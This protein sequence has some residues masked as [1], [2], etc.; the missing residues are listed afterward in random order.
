MASEGQPHHANGRTKSVSNT[1]NTLDGQPANWA[2][3]RTSGKKL[4][5]SMESCN[6][7]L[8]NTSKRRCSSAIGAH[9]S[10]IRTTFPRDGEPYPVTR[11][12]KVCTYAQHLRCFGH[13]LWCTS[14]IKQKLVK[15]G[16]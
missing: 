11:F 13:T 9:R 12:S 2:A 3:K 5:S 15:R 7:R 10:D 14:K 6:R 8:R 4:G 16:F 1:D